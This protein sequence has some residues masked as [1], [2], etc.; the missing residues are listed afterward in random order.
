MLLV[1]HAPAFA[2]QA[3]SIRGVV[4]DADFDAP[5]PVAKVTI[6]ET[7]AE[8]T[9]TEEGNYAFTDVP[10]GRYTL[11]F[12]K[13]GYARQVRTDVVVTA[14]QLT[15]VDA[16]LSGEFIEMEEFIVQDLQ[17]GGATEIGLLELRERA[18]ALIDSISADLLSQAGASD[19]AS[20]LRL[21]SGASIQEGKFAVI[22]G[23]P[24][25]YVNSQI[26][27]IRLPT[28]DAEKRAV[29]LDQFPAAIIESI[30]VSKTFTPDQQG[31]A[32]GGAVN[33]MLKG[34]P[35]ST[36]IS[37]KS[38]LDYNSQVQNREDFLTYD[39]GGVNFFGNDRGKRD[40]QLDRLGMNWDGA[41]GV[42]RGQAPTQ[43]KW[44]VAGGLNHVF[45]TG[46]KIGG[47][48]NVFYEQ[49]ASFHDNGV[50]DSLWIR[51]P[52]E[53]LTPQ[54]TQGAPSNTDPE[55]GDFRTAL[56]DITEATELVQWGALATFGIETDN[57]A[58][59]FTYLYTRI[60]ED[61]ATLA[62]DTRGKRF[63]FPDYD[64][65]DSMHPGN[66]VGRDAAPFL[67][68]QTLE[69]TE[70]TTETVQLSG[71]HTLPVEG[72]ELG[73]LLTF[74]EP[75]VDWSVSQSTATLD[76][77]DKR[78]FGSAWFGPSFRP[79]FPPFVPPFTVPAEFRPF[80]P[81]ANF[82][83]GNSQRIF[84]YIEEESEQYAINLSLPF[85]QWTGDEGYF[86]FGLF[87]DDVTRTFDQDTFSNFGDN[88][89]F[90]AESFDIFWSDVF[91]FQD[92]PISDGPPFVDVDY[93][94][95]QDISAWHAMI[96]LPVTSWLNVIGG[97]RFERTKIGI[98][99]DAEENA[100]WFPTGAV[101][102]VQLNPGDADVQFEQEDILPSISLVVRPVD[103]LTFR[104]AYSETVARQTFREI[105]P[106][107]QQEFLGGDIFIGN[108][109]L[110]MSALKNYDLRLDYN[111]YPGGLVS[112]S[113]FQKDVEDP[114]EIIQRL[115][116][117]TF[118]TPVNFPE[119]ELEG[120][121]FEVRQDLGY[122]FEEMQGL[123]IGGNI[124]FIESEVT[125]PNELVD[126]FA[127][128]A[129]QVPQTTR[130][131]TET[132]EFLY[133]LY[134]T[135]DLQATGTQFAVF[136]T[137]TG[138]KLVAGA[139]ESSGN[140]V[141]DVYQLET[142]SLNLSISQRIGEHLKLTFKAKNLTNPTIEEV[143][144]SG[145]I[146]GDVTKTSFTRGIDYSIG[147]SAEFK[148]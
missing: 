80:K 19:A 90:Q 64:P 95:T 21:V 121:E 9:A 63:F 85:E 147:L 15:D 18:P 20:A 24:D 35:E 5:L 13:Q 46:V 16:R 113:Y 32:S 115:V 87:E 69:Y 31:D 55:T 139:G 41:A 79:G 1:L 117:F 3:G 98:V 48:A 143:Y 82:T 6:V 28:A 141:P 23:L 37:F 131:M 136:Y 44:S 146:D 129:L 33:I 60:A 114:I 2:Q 17:I 39:G 73:D 14:G 77:P 81:A 103:Q 74:R 94:G 45:D 108:P 66:I 7:G 97:A 110:T 68:T 118:T 145:F 93:R 72:S 59:D 83:L 42:T 34:I 47:Y 12:S 138:D 104:A 40:P 99:N 52:G 92:H 84:K 53:G 127:S 112:V 137:V 29:Q 107:Q 11:V 10:P 88:T 148:F 128:P 126:Q 106:I 100:T 22:R 102:P 122:F 96:D 101:S 125:L 116:G 38:Q 78:Q 27:G 25:R 61:T 130:D 8:V 133:N 109:E 132:P 30:Q 123:Q 51:N 49:D 124:T 67:R 56:F 144:R 111:P 86:K 36:F 119:G 43:Y 54:T 105:T 91:P 62:E 135:Y 76:Q 134:L 120:F 70:R 57:H 75:I 89:G 142:G 58:V 140:F 26:N 4:Y 71:R 50:N 65:Q